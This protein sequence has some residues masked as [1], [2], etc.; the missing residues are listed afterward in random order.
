[1]W[2][3]PT[4]TG[5]VKFVEQFKNP[6]TL[7]YTRVSITMDKETNSTRKLAQQ[8]LN[9]RIEEK[10]RQL[11][12]GH[13]KEGVT[14]GELIDEFDRYYQPT[15]KP[16]TFAS[17]RNIR[18]RI[19]TIFNSGILVSKITNKYL[20]NTLEATINQYGYSNAYA[21]GIIAMVNQLMNFA[22]RHDYI[23]APIGQIKVNWK[24]NN[25]AKNIEN[26]YLEDNE[27]SLVLNA[28]RKIN[29]TN[30]DLFLWQYLTGMRIGEILALQVKKVF[31]RANRWY[32]KINC[33]LEYFA[34]NRKK[35]KISDS[36]KTQSSNRIISL[37]DQAVD[38]YR[39]HSLHKRPD[40]LLFS[41]N[42]EF[43][44][45]VT[46]HSELVKVKKR[47]NLK[48]TLSSHIFRHTHASKLAELGMPIELISKRLGHKGSEITRQIY[49]H[50]TKKTTEQYSGLIDNLKI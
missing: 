24:R 23:A 21:R 46:L 27:V 35:F 18:K 2:T 22:Y 42:G 10:L 49:L 11:Q 28:V 8:M 31:Q 50:I 3:E 15:V 9:K 19:L 16:S 17:W 13:I 44:H 43:I 32:V 20:S 34:G 25:S 45:P 40:D 29:P 37:S 38:I 12:D 36:P 41:Y 4:K 39:K 7:K 33:T 48:K 30:A 1:M 14:F 6:L 47:L 26:K 5:K